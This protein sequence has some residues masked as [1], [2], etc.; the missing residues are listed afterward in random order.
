MSHRQIYVAI[1]GLLLAF[2][3][4]AALWFPVYLD[5]YDAYGIKISRGNGIGFQL[6]HISHDV[7]ASTAGCGKALLIRRAWAIPTVALGWLLL[8]WAAIMWVHNGQQLSDEPEH[9]VPHPEIY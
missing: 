1:V 5:Q 9:M 6:A 3:G 8:T 7:N 4:L 2:V